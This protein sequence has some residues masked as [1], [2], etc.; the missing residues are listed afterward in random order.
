M[1]TNFNFKNWYRRVHA[2]MNSELNRGKA[3]PFGHLGLIRLTIA[4]CSARMRVEELK[5]SVPVSQTFDMLWAGLG[6]NIY[7]LHL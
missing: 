7:R 2:P 5:I 3:Q 4:I 1:K 6:L